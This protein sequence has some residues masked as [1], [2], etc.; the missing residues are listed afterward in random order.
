MLRARWGSR[1][2]L[3]D[4]NA[5]GS[6]ACIFRHIEDLDDVV[7]NDPFIR[8]NDH[9]PLFILRHKGLKVGP[10][11]SEGSGFVA[12][13]DLVTAFDVDDNR[14]TLL[15]RRLDICLREFNRDS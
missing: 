14:I 10:E 1:G 3:F 11:I 4:G 5:Q 6:H 15:H 13:E 12:E 2:L 9:G 7:E 8:A